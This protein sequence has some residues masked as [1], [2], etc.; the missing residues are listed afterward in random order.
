MRI[1][2]YESGGRE[3][4]G[5]V[6]GDMVTPVSG[7]LF[8]PKQPSGAAVPLSGVKLLSPVAPRTMYAVAL[9]YP[10]HLG[11][12]VAAPRPEI[13]VKGLNSLAGPTDQIVLPRSAGRVDYEGEIVVV[14]GKKAKKVSVDDAL[15]HVYGYS[16][17]NDVSAREWQNGDRQW[18]RGK[19]CDTFGVIGPWVVD[20]LD[21]NDIELRTRLNGEEVQH[22]NSSEMINS[23]AETISFISQ[24][25]TLEVGD[26]I[27]TG[28]SGKP[29]AMKHGDVVEVDVGGVGVLRNEVIDDPIP[30]TW[31]DRR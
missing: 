20:G 25:A 24:V 3:S 1:A 14:I 28:T 21:A 9:N 10:S 31:Q 30:A 22:C 17:G 16:C 13:F 8:G 26:V 15:S 12:Q 11:E 27:F 6:D 7:G 5:L 29:R 2:R 18:F 4:Y 19:S 23:I